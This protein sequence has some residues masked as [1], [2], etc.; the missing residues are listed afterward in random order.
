MYP[1]AFDLLTRLRAWGRTVILSDGDVVFQ[2]RK[3]ERSPL[4]DAVDGHVLVYIH[5]E[6]E[7]DDIAR[8][9]PADHYVFVDD[10]LRLLTAFKDAWGR[11][12]TTVFPRQG[13]YATD[14]A[15]QARY[16]AAD[17]TIERT[18]DLLEYDRSTARNT[19]PG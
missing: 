3:I 12:V 19:G 10:K 13:H 16:A 17:I 5:K 7:V 11:R 14:P 4:F 8:R 2:P 6:Q 18:G 9:H 15:E 1:G